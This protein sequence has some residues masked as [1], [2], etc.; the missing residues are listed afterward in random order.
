MFR[1][2][3]FLA[4]LP[5]QRHPKNLKFTARNGAS[6]DKS[7]RTAAWCGH[8]ELREGR[9]S[10]AG[11]TRVAATPPGTYPR[12]Y[13]SSQKGD[14]N[15]EDEGMPAEK[16]VG[17]LGTQQEARLR[18]H[19]SLLVA[20]AYHLCCTCRL[21]IPGETL[22]EFWGPAT[23]LH[24]QDLPGALNTIGINTDRMGQESG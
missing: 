7:R 13:P 4:R 21:R 22:R 12:D 6:R 2:A 17:K 3:Q 24:F 23:R 11:S 9:G 10:L 16:R 19:R 15:S 18:S 20:G 14:G 1:L 5:A 8:I